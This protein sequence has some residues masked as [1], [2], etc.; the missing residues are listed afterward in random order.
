MKARAH[1]LMIDDDPDFVSATRT[2]LESAN[3]EVDVAYNPKEGMEALGKKNYDL[4]LLD[5]MMGRGAE[6]VLIAR[7]L[8]KDPAMRRLPV[9][10]ITG[11]REQ[12]RFLF[13]GQALR[14]HLLPVDELIEKP[15]NPEEL[16][17]KV[18]ALIARRPEAESQKEVA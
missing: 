1:I 12:L 10:I 14:P 15:V 13:P 8:R 6:G 16:L 18:H 7:K 4:L 2:L 3:Y 9:L 11:I 17:K 5:I